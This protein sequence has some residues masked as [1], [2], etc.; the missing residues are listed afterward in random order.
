MVSPATMADVEQAEDVI[1][2]HDCATLRVA[3]VF[4]KIDADQPPTG[5]EVQAM[6]LAAMPTPQVLWRI[7]FTVMS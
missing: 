3:G 1:T 6:A 7:A 5:I 2:H 4:L